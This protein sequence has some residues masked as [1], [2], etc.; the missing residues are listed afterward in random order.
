MKI[1]KW[2]LSASVIILLSAC[3]SLLQQ[4]DPPR[5]ELINLQLAET[6]GL[7]QNFNLT[8]KLQNPNPIPIPI[9]GMSFDLSLLDTR[10][11]SGVS[12]ESVRVPA[13]GE[14]QIKIKVSTNLLQGVSLLRKLSKQSNG[15][16][17]TYQI[18]GKI[19]TGLGL[20]S[21][22]PIKKSGSIDINL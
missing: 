3:N 2:F 17:L 19:Q 20:L 5:I 22:V 18:D 16:P 4:I 15:Q 10:F 8:F 11:A 6:E 12:N 13:F 7:S 9:Q 21:S 14:Q 1:L